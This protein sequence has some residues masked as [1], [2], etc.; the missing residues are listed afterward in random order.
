MYRQDNSDQEFKFLHVFSGIE[1]CEKWREVRL[2][3]TKAKETYKPDTLVPTAAEGCPDGTKKT[4]EARDAAPVV[5][6]LQSS[7]TNASPMPRTTPKK[8]NT[9]LAF[10][11]G[12]DMSTMDEQVKAW[13][14]AGRGLILNQMPAPATTTMVTMTATPMTTPNPST[15]TTPTTSL[16]PASPATEE[17]HYVEPAV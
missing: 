9:D 2:A 6:W 1:S 4:R 11:M 16:T 5:E 10:L 17:P 14:L 13:Y 7:I 15:E 8:S 3:L 12:A